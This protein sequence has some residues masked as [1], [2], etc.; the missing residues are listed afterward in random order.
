[1]GK[2]KK[3]IRRGGLPKVKYT[4][5]VAGTIYTSEIPLRPVEGLVNGMPREG[6]D[7][8]WEGRSLEVDGGVI[9]RARQHFPS[10]LQDEDIQIFDHGVNHY[11]LADEIERYLDEAMG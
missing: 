2:R 9:I 10:R 5:N 4:Q 11:G 6:I 8:V 3:A 7:I 1:M